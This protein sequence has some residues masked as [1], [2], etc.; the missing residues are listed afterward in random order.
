[1][2]E[3]ILDTETTGLDPRKG[4]RLVE[5]GCI[6]IVNRIPTGRE[7][8]CFINPERDVPAE[9]EKVHG[10]STDFLKDKPLFRKVAREFLQFIGDDRLVI[11][12]AQFDIGFLNFELE[13]A[14]LGSIAMDRVVDTLAPARRKQ[15]AATP[16]GKRHKG[17]AGLAH[18]RGIADRLRGLRCVHCLQ[19][20]YG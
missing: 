6:E 18:C 3:V 17:T 1:M 13:R 15:P 4:D 14:G 12:N 9:A 5:I 20:G 10:L 2:R 16:A 19:P 8:H 11:H 7:Y